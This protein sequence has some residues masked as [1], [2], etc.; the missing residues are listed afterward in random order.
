MDAG[1][2]AVVGDAVADCDGDEDRFGTEYGYC[3]Y[4]G[5]RY[6]LPGGWNDGERD[7]SC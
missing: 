6:D 3:Y 2:R 1:G 4:A 7:D 5:Y